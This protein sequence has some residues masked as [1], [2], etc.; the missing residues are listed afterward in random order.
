MPRRRR[1]GSRGGWR[2]AR[3]ARRGR[4]ARRARTPCAGPP[5]A[6]MVRRPRRAG[7]RAQRGVGVRGGG[8]GR[9]AGD[10]ASAARSWLRELGNAGV[11]TMKGPPCIFTE[12]LVSKTRAAGAL[13]ADLAG[14]VCGTAMATR[15]KM[16]AEII[17]EEPRTWGSE[18]HDLTAAGDRRQVS[19]FLDDDPPSLRVTAGG[20]YASMPYFPVGGRGAAAPRRAPSLHRAGTRW[21]R[22][23]GRRCPARHC[24][25]RGR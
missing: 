20:S 7:P 1:W 9:E 24:P 15:P 13:G 25:E 21:Q 12:G 10:C 17:I 11:L 18:A 8:G 19:Y 23:S 4:R 5:Q 2:R 14:R 22:R 3:R 16:T 6:Q